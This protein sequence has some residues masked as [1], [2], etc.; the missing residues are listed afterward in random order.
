MLDPSK[1]DL[2]EDDTKH[3]ADLGAAFRRIRQATGVPGR[4]LDHFGMRVFML[5]AKTSWLLSTTQKWAHAL[6]RQLRWEIVGLDAPEELLKGF[7]WSA[8]DDDL[9][10]QLRRRVREIR[11]YLNIGTRE[12]DRLLGQSSPRQW[13]WENDA[14]RDVNLVTLQRVFRAMGGQLVFSLVPLHNPELG[15]KRGL[16]QTTS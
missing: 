12:M 2:H 11:E 14:N 16:N 9:R 3:R 15:A 10:M 13:R 5:E 7:D 1:L 8:S 6:R 4:S